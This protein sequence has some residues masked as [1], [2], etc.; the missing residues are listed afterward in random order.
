MREYVALTCP[1]Q[2]FNVIVF[3]GD[4]L[5]DLVPA[6]D[7]GAAALPE[8]IEVEAATDANPAP[9]SPVSTPTT[10]IASLSGATPPM[11]RAHVLFGN[12]PQA[13]KM[14]SC[15][16]ADARSVY[17][18]YWATGEMDAIGGSDPGNPSF[19]PE[20]ALDGFGMCVKV[21]TFGLE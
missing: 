12:H 15:I 4:S 14:S 2:S 5:P 11:L 13:M 21:W 18:T 8:P 9:D 16:Q 1:S 3:E 7:R 10:S 19:P 6:A 20:P 17:L